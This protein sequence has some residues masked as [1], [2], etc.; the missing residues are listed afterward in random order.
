[1]PF[2][3]AVERNRE[4]RAV[5]MHPH[6]VGAFRSD[7]L[8]TWGRCHLEPGAA[9]LSDARGCLGAVQHAG[10]F[11]RPSVTGSGAPGARHPAPTRVDTLLGSIRRS[12]HG[13]YHHLSFQA[14]APIPAELSGWD[15]AGEFARRGREPVVASPL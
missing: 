1:M 12:L 8:A 11:H 10:C 9:V 15:L 13:T 3:A 2:V 6:R 4:G 5:R 14:P 7:D